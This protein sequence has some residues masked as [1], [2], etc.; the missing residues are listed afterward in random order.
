M[1]LQFTRNAKI[2]L[3]ETTGGQAWQ[4]NVLQDFSFSQTV[5]STEIV[6]NEA[7][8][9]SRRARLIFNDNL[10]PA[11]GILALMLNHSQMTQ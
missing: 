8:S 9:T 4:V 5:N 10:A 6:I 3:V 11:N 7:G 1:A 2:Y